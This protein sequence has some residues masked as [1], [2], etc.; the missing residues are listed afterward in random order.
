MTID[1]MLCSATCDCEEIGYVLQPLD[2]MFMELLLVAYSETTSFAFSK[3]L[4][5][6]SNLKINIHPTLVQ[7]DN[8]FH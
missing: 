6:D 2:P 1:L 7:I 8:S 4:L 5:T 3:T